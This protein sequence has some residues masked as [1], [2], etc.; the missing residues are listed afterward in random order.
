MGAPRRGA[1]QVPKPEE[2]TSVFGWILAF[3]ATV[4]ARYIAKA[5]AF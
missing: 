5:L 3:A 4:L 1:G 2:V